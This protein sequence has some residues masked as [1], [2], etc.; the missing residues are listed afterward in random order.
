[1]NKQKH[2]SIR[3]DEEVL[4]KFHYVSRYNGRSASGQ[5][6]YLIN[7]CIRELRRSRAKSNW[8][9]RT[10]DFSPQSATI[11]RLG[12]YDLR[13]RKIMEEMVFRL[14]HSSAQ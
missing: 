5:I 10:L 6:L 8:N 4:K 13:R 9:T 7:Q 3:I 11:M 14:A 12:E 2:I 1:M